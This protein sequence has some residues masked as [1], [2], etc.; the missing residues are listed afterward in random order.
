[1]TLN[2]INLFKRKSRNNIITLLLFILL[3]MNIVKHLQK[4]NHT[5]ICI[6]ISFFSTYVKNDICDG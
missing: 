3:S 5:Y 4:T 1:M 6:Y 2:L